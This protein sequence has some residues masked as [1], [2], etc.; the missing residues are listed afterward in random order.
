MT[1]DPTAARARLAELQRD[2]AIRTLHDVRTELTH[3][4]EEH[5][6]SELHLAAKIRDAEGQLA[7]ARDTIAHMEQSAFWRARAWLNRLRGR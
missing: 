1:E 7:Q 6:A 4:L 5:R 3:A 2:E